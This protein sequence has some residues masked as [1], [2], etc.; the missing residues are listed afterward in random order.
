MCEQSVCSCGDHMFLPESAVINPSLFPIFPL[1]L[2]SS[3]RDY[4]VL[5]N[6]PEDDMHSFIKEPSGGGS[7]ASNPAKI[8]R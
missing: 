6:L 4:T 8:H 5:D 1:Y 2:V 7:H 3:G